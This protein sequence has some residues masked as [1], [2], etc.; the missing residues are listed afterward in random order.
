MKKCRQIISDSILVDYDPDSAPIVWHHYEKIYKDRI[1]H[2]LNDIKIVY[3]KVCRQR[4]FGNKGEVTMGS[5]TDFTFNE[6][7]NNKSPYKTF[8]KIIEKSK[9]DE[10]KKEELVNNLEKCSKMHH[11][12][13]NF[14]P[15]PQ[16]GGMNNFKGSRRFDRFIYDLSQFYVKVEEIKTDVNDAELANK[17]YKMN[18]KNIAFVPSQY[19]AK[20]YKNNII[21]LIEYLL[22]FDNIYDYCKR[23]YLIEEEYVNKLLSFYHSVVEQNGD[24]KRDI[25][26][27]EKLEE[28]IHLANEYWDIREKFIENF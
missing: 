10:K 15:M 5:D 4:S 26:T 20:R 2:S 28:Y 11:T 7:K 8:E 24:K 3:G 13:L 12:L 14:S 16:T 6:K 1:Y 21:L 22:K 25:R 9:L 23:I 18:S 27:T 17:L 19:R